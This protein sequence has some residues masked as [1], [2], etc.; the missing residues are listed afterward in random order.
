MTAKSLEQALSWLAGLERFSVRPGLERMEYMME[1]LGHPERRL[2]FIHIAGTNGKGS[3]AAFLQSILRKA[4]HEVGLFVSPY[5]VSFHERI[6]HNGEPIAPEDLLALIERIRPIVEE[7]KDAAC[8]APTEFE[9]VTALALLYFATVSYPDI[10]V[11][12]TG[13]G[14]R[15]DSTNIVH[16]LACIITNVGFD[17]MNIL[18]G[19]LHAIAR[20][21]AGIIK[22]G[23]PVITGKMSEEALE[24]IESVARERKASLYREGKEY[25]AVRIRKGD[26]EIL[27]FSGTFG[28]YN[29]C[30]L[31]L[32]GEHQ[33]HNAAVAVMALQ[34]LSNYFAL[35][36][37]E[38]HIRTGLREAKWP[39]RFEKLAENPDVIL[40]GAHNVDGVKAL[41]KTLQ[42][43]YPGQKVSLVFSALVDKNYTEMAEL[44][45]PLCKQVWVTKTD[46]PRAAEPE[47]LANAFRTARPDLHIYAIT[48]WQEAWRRA[49]HTVHEQDVLLVA[50]SLYFISDIRN[51]WK[52]NRKAG[53][54]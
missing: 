10:V 41:T 43:Y 13:L 53:D 46:H 3:T 40:D 5:V 39:G 51:E 54:E 17:H 6:Q 24:V 27:D 12:E 28:I 30:E 35:Y 1:R 29:R 8:G 2:K 31:G 47:A 37:E 32:V 14:G 20:E 7:M 52:E 49:L 34:V 18:G 15:L 23:V 48:E 44:L 45:A 26:K 38:E 16:P 11:W 4:G 25:E 36:V 19:D 33:M 21:K 9:V 22:N 42:D 50:G